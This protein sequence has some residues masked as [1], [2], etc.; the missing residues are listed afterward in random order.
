MD[1][2]SDEVGEENTGSQRRFEM[3]TTTRSFIQDQTTRNGNNSMMYPTDS[4]QDGGAFTHQSFFNNR[5]PA[6]FDAREERKVGRR[7]SNDTESDTA[8]MS[9][10]CDE[11]RSYTPQPRQISM[12][13]NLKTQTSKYNRGMPQNAITNNQYT[14]AGNQGM[15]ANRSMM[16]FPGERL[17]NKTTLSCLNNRSEL[18]VSDI[19]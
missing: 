4:G 19:S 14:I 17:V 15:M 11:K 10:E 6:T 1:K 12:L 13:A 16:G 18:G 9:D 7:E 2:Q 3:Q 8:F 5:L